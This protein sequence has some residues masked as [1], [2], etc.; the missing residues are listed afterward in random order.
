[1]NQQEWEAERRRTGPTPCAKA[2][3]NALWDLGVENLLDEEFCILDQR[4]YPDIYIP[5][6]EVVVEVDGAYHSNPDQKAKDAQRTS[7]LLII[8]ENVIRVQNWEVRDDVRKV[9]R[10]IIAQIE[11]EDYERFDGDPGLFGF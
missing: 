6:V 11:W 8:F 10:K 4:V 9:A 3:S 1:M 7:T 5:D 2:L